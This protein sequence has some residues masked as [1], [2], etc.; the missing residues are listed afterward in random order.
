M[1][2]IDFWYLMTKFK[3]VMAQL[4]VDCNLDTLNSLILIIIKNIICMKLISNTADR[5]MAHKLVDYR[6]CKNIEK[7][8][9]INFNLFLYYLHNF[10]YHFHLFKTYL[11]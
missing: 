5:P 3:Q 11:I 7:L 8:N 9:L 2:S 6:Y 1:H 4:F 10:S